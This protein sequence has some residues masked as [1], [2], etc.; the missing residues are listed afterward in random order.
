MNDLAALTP[1]MRAALSDWLAGLSALGNAS[2]HT[3]IAYRHDVV[4]WMVFSPRIMAS[5]PVRRQLPA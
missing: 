1:Q 4:N 5:R 2:G 3:I